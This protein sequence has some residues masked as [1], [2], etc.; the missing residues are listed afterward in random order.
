MGNNTSRKDQRRSR[1]GGHAVHAL[2]KIEELR[3]PSVDSY[4]KLIAWLAEMAENDNVELDTS[5]F[6]KHLSRVCDGSKPNKKCQPFRQNSASCESHTSH[7]SSGSQR[8]NRSTRSVDDSLD[9]RYILRQALNS[10]QGTFASSEDY[11][12][13]EDVRNASM[14]SLYSGSDR[15]S[16]LESIATCDSS[17]RSGKHPKYYDFKKLVGPSGRCAYSSSLGDLD[18]LDKQPTS[19]NLVLNSRRKSVSL[20]DLSPHDRDGFDYEERQ[21]PSPPPVTHKD[22]SFLDDKLLDGNIADILFSVEALWG[23]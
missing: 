18:R 5:V 22:D 23:K 8:F 6:V 9:P 7:A 21:A 20:L 19:L 2:N 1:P 17:I 16:E 13:S 11:E 12:E 15:D 4:D 14:E 3:G 10:R